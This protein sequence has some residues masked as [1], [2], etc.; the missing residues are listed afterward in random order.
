VFPIDG[1]EIEVLLS[2][3]EACHDSTTYFMIPALQ[4]GADYVRP[5]AK[6]GSI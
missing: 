5:F 3:W 4:A 1:T 6:L 2:K